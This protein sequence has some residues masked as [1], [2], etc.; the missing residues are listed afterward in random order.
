MKKLERFHGKYK[1]KIPFKCFECG[2]IGHLLQN[3]HIRKIEIVMTRW[4]IIKMKE[5]RHK[6]E[7]DFKVTKGLVNKQKVYI[8]MRTTAHHMMIVTMTRENY[9]S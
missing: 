4:I 3:S 6:N 9:S 2:K 7:A 5:E 8:P 1:G